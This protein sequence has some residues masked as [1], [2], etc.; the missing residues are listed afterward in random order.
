MSRV[1]TAALF[2]AWLLRLIVR[3]G[4]YREP[5]AA[6]ELEESFFSQALL[7]GSTRRGEEGRALRG[8]GLI[9]RRPGDGEEM[10]GLGEERGA[11]GDCDLE[12]TRRLTT[13]GPQESWQSRLDKVLAEER[14]RR[15]VRGQEGAQADAT[16]AI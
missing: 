12:R 14:D 11:S 1:A 9:R 7:K 8:R 10:R 5:V 16:G 4:S 6:E 13:G 15:R 2:S 3:G